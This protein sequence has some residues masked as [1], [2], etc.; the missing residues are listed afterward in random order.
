MPPLADALTREHHEIDG[1]IEE[2]VASLNFVDDGAPDTAPLS[3][4]MAALRRHIYL[5]EEILFPAIEG[6]ALMMPLMVMYREHGQIWRTMDV[7]EMFL[8]TEAAHG[9][10]RDVTA[11]HCQDLLDLLERHNAKEEPIIYPHADADL[12]EAAREHLA[13]FLASGTL[14][15]GWVCREADF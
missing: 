4:A 1:G 9:A 5:E 6:P 10:H 15:E 8:A 14:P 3:A 2:F 11:G 7:L 12:P 13:D